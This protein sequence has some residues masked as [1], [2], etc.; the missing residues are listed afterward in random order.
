MQELMH[1]IL[2]KHL[3]LSINCYMLLMCL[4]LHVLCYMLL[5]GN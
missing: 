2:K 4:F 5:C 3:I 1:L